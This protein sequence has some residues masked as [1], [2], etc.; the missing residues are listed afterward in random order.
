MVEMPVM[1][2]LVRPLK[3]ATKEEALGWNFCFRSIPGTSDNDT[4]LV[5]LR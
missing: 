4:T 5:Q 1:L 2:P 3:G